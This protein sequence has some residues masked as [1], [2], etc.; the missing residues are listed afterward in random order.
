MSLTSA[1]IG[2]HFQCSL[3]VLLTSNAKNP[4]CRFLYDFAHLHLRCRTVGAPK[5]LPRS[6]ILC[7]LD[8]NN[9]SN[10]KLTFMD[11]SRIGDPNLP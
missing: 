9:L 10:L 8:K 3:H 5:I 6:A 7:K 4:E 11:D 2:S 1:N